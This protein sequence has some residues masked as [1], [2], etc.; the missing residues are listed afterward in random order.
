MKLWDI[1]RRVAAK[2]LGKPGLEI[3]AVWGNFPFTYPN[4][5]CTV[6]K[7]AGDSITLDHEHIREFTFDATEF[8][9]L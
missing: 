6:H 8:R 9:K 1:C 5:V 4:Q 3:V 7:K 2:E